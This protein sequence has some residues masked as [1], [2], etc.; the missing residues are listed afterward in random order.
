ME[1]VLSIGLILDLN[2]LLASPNLVQSWH[3]AAHL[4]SDGAFV[5]HPIAAR[6][7]TGRG[8]Q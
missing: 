2:C 6:T 5:R 7:N 3:L 4:Q 8:R 1:C